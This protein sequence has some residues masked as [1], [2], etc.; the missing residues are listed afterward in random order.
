MQS[1]TVEVGEKRIDDCNVG[2]AAQVNSTLGFILRC[3]VQPKAI[4]NQVICGVGRIFGLDEIAHVE[5]R[6]PTSD[7]KSDETI[8]ICSVGEKDWPRLAVAVK[9]QLGHYIADRRTM[10]VR[11]RW[12]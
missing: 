5:V 3:T 4:K 11:P 7:L 8:V 12:K 6:H 2:S 1:N 10:K 9:F